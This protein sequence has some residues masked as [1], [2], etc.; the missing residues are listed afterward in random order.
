MAGLGAEDGRTADQGDRTVEVLV[1]TLRA[2]AGGTPQ[3]TVV[4]RDNGIGIPA[5]HQGEVFELFRR[6]HGQDERGGGTGVGLAIV[7]RIVERHGGE[8]WL[9]SEPGCGSSFYFTLGHEG[10]D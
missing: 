3:Q 9:E 7:K 2:P 8:L 4:V 6:L 1:D 5:D 10:G